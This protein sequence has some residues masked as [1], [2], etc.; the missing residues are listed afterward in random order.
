MSRT[1]IKLSPSSSR[2]LEG[3]NIRFFESTLCSYSPVN[4]SRTSVRDF[5]FGCMWQILRFSVCGKSCDIIHHNETHCHHFPPLWCKYYNIQTKINQGE[6]GNLRGKSFSFF[7]IF[8]L[9]VWISALIKPK[10]EAFE[11]FLQFFSSSYIY[12]QLGL[13]FSHACASQGETMNATNVTI[14]S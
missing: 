1:T 6:L 9:F 5:G 13:L 3:T 8:I 4:I 10:N 14:K 12:F 7:N 11:C 2:N